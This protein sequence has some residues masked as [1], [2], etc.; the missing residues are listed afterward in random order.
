MSEGKFD[1]AIELIINNAS[2][3][4]STDPNSFIAYFYEAKKDYKT[5]IE[6]LNKIISKSQ[7]EDLKLAKRLALSYVGIGEYEI[8]ELQINKVLK[9]DL[10][11]K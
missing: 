7:L 2:K 1:N 6:Y 10:T 4:E 9:S 5:A 3:I 11:T 8:A